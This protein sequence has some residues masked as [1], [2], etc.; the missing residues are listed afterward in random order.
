ML[1]TGFPGCALSGHLFTVAP[2]THSWPASIHMLLI[3]LHYSQQHTLGKHPAT[4]KFYGLCL[5]GCFPCTGYHIYST[6]RNGTWAR[7]VRAL[8]LKLDWTC[9]IWM[10]LKLSPD[11]TH[12]PRINSH[13]YVPNLSS[14]ITW[15]FLPTCMRKEG[16]AVAGTPT[17]LPVTFPGV[18]LSG[19]LTHR[20]PLL[21]PTF[22]FPWKQH[23]AL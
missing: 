7:E 12:S 13:I 8:V 10:D 22:H 21:L 17:L 1:Q 23:F 2:H 6:P 9:E 15:H 18:L 20:Q 19:L 4:S 5:Q 3:H 16:S 14:L 11:V